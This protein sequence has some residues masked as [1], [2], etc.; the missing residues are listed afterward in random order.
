MNYVFIIDEC[1]MHL[2]SNIFLWFFIE[3]IIT[4][5]NA[6]YF[7]Q[8]FVGNMFLVSYYIEL[9]VLDGKSLAKDA[10]NDCIKNLWNP[11][12][13]LYKQIDLFHIEQCICGFVKAKLRMY[14]DKYDPSRVWLFSIQMYKTR[15]HYHGIGP[16]YW[17]LDYLFDPI[18]EY[19]QRLSGFDSWYW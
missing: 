13:A 2:C 16:Q 10:A 14:M 9:V 4:H 12:V 5:M 17:A 6:I 7:S 8:F 15:G 19:H 1:Y 11:S 3:Y 18:Q